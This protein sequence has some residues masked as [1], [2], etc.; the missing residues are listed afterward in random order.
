MTLKHLILLKGP[1]HG[2]ERSV[3][4][5]RM[6]QELAKTDAQAGITFCGVADAMLYAT[7]GHMTPDSFQ[8]VERMI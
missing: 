4:G 6:A 2:S 8:N 3:D 7:S 1:P 5:L